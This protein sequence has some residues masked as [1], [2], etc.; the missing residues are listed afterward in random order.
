MM[1]SLIESNVF[2][3]DGLTDGLTCFYDFCPELVVGKRKNIS[4]FVSRLQN[5]HELHH[6]V[7]PLPIQED[8]DIWKIGYRALSISRRNEE[9]P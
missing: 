1:L 6:P 5:G 8:G 9:G 7:A 4:F 2:E 3:T